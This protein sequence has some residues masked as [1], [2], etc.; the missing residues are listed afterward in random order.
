MF[1]LLRSK[2]SEILNIDYE[3]QW[4]WNFPYTS[5]IG[6]IVQSAQCSC[7]SL[8]LSVC[9]LYVT[10]DTKIKFLYK[11]EL[12]NLLQMIRQCWFVQCEH[13]KQSA[14]TDKDSNNTTVSF[15]KNLVQDVL[16]CPTIH[17]VI[18]KTTDI[19]L[20]GPLSVG[21]K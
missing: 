5:E 1:L 16:D 2:Y 7:V 8:T 13:Q 6:S 20:T 9:S 12:K 15:Y 19:M 21:R 3:P 4:K 17:Q 14:F 18:R 10:K 11:N